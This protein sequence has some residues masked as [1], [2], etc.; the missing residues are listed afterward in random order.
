MATRSIGRGASAFGHHPAGVE[1]RLARSLDRLTQYGQ[2]AAAACDAAAVL[3]LTADAA[4]G[5]LHA[6]AAAVLT[7]DA[8]EDRW[9]VAAC[10][11]VSPEAVRRW[12]QGVDGGRLAEALRQ[13][14]PIELPVSVGAR[15]E[16][17]AGDGPTSWPG[18]RLIGVPMVGR[19]PR[20]IGVLV[21]S[22]RPGRGLRQ[23]MRGRLAGLLAQ[24]ASAACD[25][26]T[27]ASEGRELYLS[28]IRSLVAAIDARD[29]S[30]RGHSQRVAFY[31]R[32][33]AE[34]LGMSP[35]W[36]E[37]VELAALLHDV[38]KI[39][40]ADSVLRKPGPLDPAERAVMMAHA[41]LGARIVGAN[42]ALAE[43]VPL[44]RHH[45]EWYSGRGYPD[46][47]KGEAIPLGAAIISVADAFDTMTTGRPYRKASPLEEA[48]AEL[49]RCAGT[50][51]HPRVV[52]ALAQALAEDE[53]AGAAYVFQLRGWIQEGGEAA[54]PAEGV[55]PAA[56][57]VHETQ[58]A[59]SG[60]W[61]ALEGARV[62]PPPSD[63]QAGRITSAHTKQL[64]A[65]YRLA[66]AL[67]DILD[68]PS[69]LQHVL[70]IIQ[71]ELGFKDCALFLVD[72][73]SD[74]LVLVAASGVFAGLEGLRLTKEQG[75]NGWVA[76]HGLPV[77]VPD[78]SR[79]PRYHPGPPTTRS[80][81]VVPMVAGS[82]V[83]G[84]LTVDS[85]R[86]DAFSVEEVQILAT[87][88]QQAAVAVEVAQMHEQSRR[89]AVRDGLTQ[90]YNHRH[91]YERLEAE[92]DRAA[93]FGHG[94]QVALGDVDRLKEVNDNFGHLAGDAV[95]ATLARVL[96][97][98]AR[99]YDTVARYGGD[100]FAIIMPQT[101]RQGALTAIARLERA[102]REATVDWQGTRLALPGVSWGVAGFPEDGTRPSELVAAADVRMYEAKRRRMQDQG[103]GS[104]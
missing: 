60:E 74:D 8:R 58:E 10:S 93:R 64:A 33:I 71:T 54:A 36:V 31:S 73:Q 12:L 15:G 52:E 83:I 70:R 85:S 40:V 49:R 88:A 48:M 26:A 2:Q 95:L 91:F 97:E 43:L 3:R 82:R 94:L 5:V 28:S 16:D 18:R 20:L 90:L 77:L 84:T 9:D 21:A 53:A 27:L 78:V 72:R 67:P 37:R 61:P 30:A 68:L 102:I 17:L 51:F 7:F 34:V 38:G 6:Q 55:V 57:P 80:E 44:V 14:R 32:R 63:R 92:V 103:G 50:Q 66:Q 42:P 86:L 45:H 75:V 56:E 22:V 65:L 4:V 100:E 46:G 47:L 1:P 101:D 19:G 96:R 104:R 11:G 35:E 41:E 98:N 69:L 62:V 23:A 79:E 81:V 89:E 87:I 13:S 59:T 99:R 29:P 76:T 25:R 24:M 39:G